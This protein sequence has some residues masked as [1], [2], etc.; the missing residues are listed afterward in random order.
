MEQIKKESGNENE[1]EN[2]NE[3][4]SVSAVASEPAALAS[5]PEDEIIIKET[6]K[7]PSLEEEKEREKTSI[8]LQLG[9]VIKISNPVNEILDQNTFMITYIDENRVDMINVE[10]FDQTTIKIDPNHILGDGNISKIELLARREFPGYAKQNG[11]LPG[12]WVS[13]HF[14]DGSVETVINGE[15]TNLE[16]DMI[17]ITTFPDNDV[18]YIN[19]DYKGLPIDLPIKSIIIKDKPERKKVVTEE[20]AEAII[21]ELEQ[22]VEAIPVIREKIDIE[23]PIK[24]VRSQ[25]REFVI[26]ADQIK[27]GKEQLG[28]IVQFIDVG[29]EKQRFSIETQTTDLL[30]ELL[31]SIP[32]IQRTNKVL[33]NIHTMIE[34]FKQLREMYS[35]FDEYGNIKNARIYEANYKP[36]LQYFKNFN[37]NLLWILPVVKNVKKIY[38]VLNVNTMGVQQSYDNDSNDVVELNMFENLNAM[39]ALIKSY[40][41]NELVD[42][43]DK[44]TSLYTNLNPYFTPFDYIDEENTDGII[45]VKEAGENI[46]TIINNLDQFYSSVM[47]NSNTTTRR[48]VIQKYNLGLNKLV[49]SSFSGPKM[50]SQVVNLTKP[51][52]M[53]IQSFITL[54]EPVIRYSRINLPG[55]SILERADL[56]NVYFN[57]WQIMKSKT[58]IND[59]FVDN[60]NED[61]EYNENNFANNIK[62]Y[63]LNLQSEDEN[64]LGK[65]DKA[66][67]YINFVKTIVPKTRILFKLMKKYIK[68]K[69]SI[70]DVVSFLEPFLVYSDNIT[71][72]LYKDII[73]F[74]DEKISA[75]NKNFTGEFKYFLE[76]KKIPSDKSYSLFKESI[77]TL[78]GKKDNLNEDVFKAYDIDTENDSKIFTNSEILQKITVKDA[79]KLYTTALTLQNI[80]LMFP[81]ELNDILESE[82]ELNKTKMTKTEESDSGECKKVV[83]AKLYKNVDELMRDNDSGD[84]YFDKIYDKTNYSILDD[85]EKEMNGMTPEAFI[86][87]LPKALEKKYKLSPSDAEYL[88]DTLISGIKRVLDGQYAIINIKNTADNNDKLDSVIEYYKRVSNRWEKDESPNIK[89]VDSDIFCNLQEKCISEVKTYESDCE[90]LKL[91]ELQIKDDLLKDILTEFDQ[92]YYKSREQFTKDITEKYNYDLSILPILTH[93]NNELMLKNNNKKYRLGIYEDESEATPVIVSPY[94][95]LLSLIIGQGDFVKK[96]ND[97][98]RFV[99]EFTRDHYNGVG[100]LGKEEMANWFYCIK[101]D[102]P[103]IPVFRYNLATCFLNAPDQYLDYI[104]ILIKEIGKLSDDGDVWVDKYSGQVISRIDFSTDE[105]FD[106]GFKVSTREIMEA[107]AG[108]KIITIGTMNKLQIVMTGEIRMIVNI[109]NALS[110]SMGINLE[111]QKEFIINSVTDMVK[112]NMP[113]ESEYKKSIKA[114]TDAGK[115]IPTYKELYNSSILYYTFG[116]YLIAIQTNMPSIKTRKTFPGCVRSFVGYPFDGS[117]DLSSINYLSCIAYKLRSSDEPWSAL[118]RT[119]EEF[120]AKKIKLAID[121]TEKTMGLLKL[122]DVMRKIDEKTEYLIMNP[123][124]DIAE[125]YDV[126]NWTNFLPPLV[127]IRIKHLVNISPEFKSGLLKDLKDGSINQRDKILVLESKIIQFSLALQEKIG[128]IVKK[129]QAILH[130]ANNEPF[131]ENACCDEKGKLSTIQYFENE[132]NTITEFNTIVKKLSDIL[133]DIGN[134][135]EAQLLYSI[136]DTKN[137][138]PPLSQAFNEK[139]IYLAFIKY[140]NFTTLIPISEDFLPLCSEKP[141]Y[142]RDSDSVDEIIRKLKEDK[143]D[144][145]NETFLRLLQ[146]VGRNNIVNIDLDNPVLNSI[147]VLTATLEEIDNENDEVVEP[148]LR[149]LLLNL[150]N[151]FS[152]EEGVSKESEKLNN[153]LIKNIETMREEITDFIDQN[154]DRGIT[155]RIQKKAAQLIQNI[156]RWETDTSIMDNKKFISNGSLYNVISF[157]KLFIKNMASIFPT[158]ILN[159]VDYNNVN[160]PAYW[161]LSMKHMGDLHK[162]ISEYYEGL[163]EF[164]NDNELYNILNT[165]QTSCKNLVLLASVTPGFSEIKYGEK[166]LKPVFEERTCKYLFEFYLLRVFI[167]FIDLSD[168]EDMIVT[169]MTRQLDVQDIFSSEYLDETET[170]N[171][172]DIGTRGQRETMLVSGNKKKLKQKVCNLIVAF[173]QIIDNHKETVDISY[174]NIK[175][176]TFKIKEREKNTFTDR[177]KSMTDEERNVDNILKVT[178]QG[179]WGKSLEKGLTSYD[180]DNYDQERDFMEMMATVDKTLR[181]NK[182]YNGEKSNLDFDDFME[183]TANAAAIEQDAYDMSNMREDYMDGDDLY[184]GAQGEDIDWGE[185]D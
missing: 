110:V 100:P 175:D 19:F 36:L 112:M 116:A 59:I 144:F 65:V 124:N 73:Q 96:Q 168:N 61:I 122:A 15:I 81:K 56:N 149:G 136:V 180:A 33:N 41:G 91:N 148:A 72:M 57:F 60:I 125:E 49:A 132:D 142:I 154:K 172:L 45:Y 166:I 155:K 28:S 102:V 104:Q 37:K 167:Q 173:T 4:P 160:L 52:V 38:N 181:K 24:D 164:Y 26:N 89:T 107:N 182:K 20:E 25:I 103:L 92:K 80:P 71:Y 14:E 34:R 70:V 185:Y 51:D 12:N 11:L 21:P 17:E 174:D 83:V 106:D 177:L 18:I 130:K 120:I 126:V 139:T 156:S 47:A 90:S 5:E 97:I 23:V 16:E 128:E 176:F 79:T 99:T 158:I 129:K 53:D 10:N 179:I 13:I 58:A 62:N 76:L 131:L 63:V 22:E 3:K 101:T 87:F 143:R 74:I 69:L 127:P 114:A 31:S 66:E 6:V 118:K 111:D 27:F 42:E 44:Y 32:N 2:E 105:G 46:T 40:R 152:V 9:D 78:L 163:R 150:L 43:N 134:Y 157:F 108:D 88:A 147:S 140:C 115:S 29:E 64:I 95:K 117:G 98:I 85:Y 161:G 84:I 119:K 55:T 159:K 145:S 178:K 39:D 133:Q 169:E 93:I 123:A 1:N 75:H 183:D 153:Y 48:F 86:D 35:D 8:E 165:I 30:D 68:G 162:V 77:I 146:L 171:D 184:T 94:S 170:R 67:I 141:D 54:P 109:I 121:G 50:I 82:K 7:E 135:T 151:K 113:E 137:I 138:Y